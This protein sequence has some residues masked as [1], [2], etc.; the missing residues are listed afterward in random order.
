MGNSNRKRRCNSRST[1]D[2][3][4]SDGQRC[5]FCFSARLL[6]PAPGDSP[7][8]LVGWL[9]PVVFLKKI[10]EIEKILEFFCFCF[11]VFQCKFD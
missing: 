3:A 4:C 6:R 8:A 7:G 2:A 10:G 11:W 5:C 9:P 1:K